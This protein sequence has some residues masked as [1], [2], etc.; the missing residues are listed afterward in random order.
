MVLRTLR[1]RNRTE[2]VLEAARRGFRVNPRR[3]LS[4]AH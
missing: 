3:T 4:R 1:V 2:A